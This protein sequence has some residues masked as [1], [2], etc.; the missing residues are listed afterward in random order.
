MKEPQMKSALSQKI[1][2]V[3]NTSRIKLRTMMPHALPS[4]QTY[5]LS[6]S[7][8]TAV[9]VATDD[10]NKSNNVIHTFTTQ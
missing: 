3:I 7:I 4:L 8:K 1:S 10:K 2:Q 9:S 6:S 5:Q